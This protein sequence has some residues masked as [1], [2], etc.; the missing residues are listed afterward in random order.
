MAASI[1]LAP[2]TDPTDA[3]E[4]PDAPAPDMPAADPRP[5]GRVL[6]PDAPRPLADP[7]T[8]ALAL[9]GDLPPPPALGCTAVAG[10]AG[11][12]IGADAVAAPRSPPQPMAAARAHD[13]AS[14]RHERFILSGSTHSLHR[15][16]LSNLVGF[17][18]EFCRS[19]VY[20]NRRV[21]HRR[22]DLGARGLPLPRARSYVPEP[23]RSP[24]RRVIST[25]KG[26][27]AHFGSEAFQR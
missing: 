20:E 2:A 3:P 24:W 26:S 23:H 1:P 21:P 16:T 5:A 11:A 6:L 4:T 7:A 9:I 25:L 18:A 15:P 27:L 8:A 22:S 12:L 14:F 19:R 17:R 10:A 13:A